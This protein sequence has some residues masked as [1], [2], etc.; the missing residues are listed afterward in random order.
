MYPKTDLRMDKYKPRQ[1][2]FLKI[3]E[4]GDWRV[5]I[6]TLTQH[7][8]FTSYDILDRVLDMIPAWI[9]NGGNQDLSNYKIATLIVHEANEGIF[10]ILNWWVDE[11][12]LQNQVYLTSPEESAGFESISDSG[13]AFCVWEL[14][15]VWHERNA[16][17]KHVLK[18]PEKPQFEAYLT[19]TY[20][21]P[22]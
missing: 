10:S 16:W 20:T 14:A 3:H 6:Y 1:A 13:I 7:E 15:I 22:T 9:K 2:T 12:M 11:N 21:G 18:N 8:Q 17:I 4:A 19:D 5:K